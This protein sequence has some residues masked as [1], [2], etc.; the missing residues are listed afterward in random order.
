MAKPMVVVMLG[1]ILQARQVGLYHKDPQGGK[2]TGGR[3]LDAH[4]KD[5]RRLI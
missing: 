1:T 2:G 3:G 4:N 5:L